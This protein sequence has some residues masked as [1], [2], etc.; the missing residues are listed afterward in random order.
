MKT[1]EECDNL[2][3]RIFNSADELGEAAAIEAANIMNEKIKEKGKV[4]IVLSTGA[5]QFQFFESFVRQSIDWSKVE[6]FHLDE[7]IGL[8]ISHA[9]SFRK[10]LQ[11][12]FVE[13]VGS[14]LGKVHYV[15]GE[16]EPEAHIRQLS[17]EITKE[18]IDLALIGIGEN[19]HIAFNDPPADF[20]TTD[21]YLIVNLDDNCKR[22]QVGEGWF[23]S[24]DDV[25]NQA[26]S[27]SVRQILKAKHIISCVPHRVK[28]GAIRLALEPAVTPDIPASILK[29]HESWSLFLDKESSSEIE[30]S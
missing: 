14:A 1:R 30:R 4:R 23:A 5:S 21:P 26:I 17:E 8:P 6:M 12:R 20:E 18:S 3:I 9:A 7:Y 2:N 24:L 11:E 15:S 22:Q 19:A 27:M 16:L 28:A 29:K 25:P 13:R 10:Y